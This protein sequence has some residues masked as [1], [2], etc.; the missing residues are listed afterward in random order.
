MK[1][2]EI[3]TKCYGSIEKIARDGGNSARVFV[4]VAWKDKR[5]LVLLLE[6]LD[7]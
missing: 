3:K 6:P 5:V 1:E 2:I 4:P 7:D